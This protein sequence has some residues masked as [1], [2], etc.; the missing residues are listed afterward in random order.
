MSTGEIS[1]TSV[2]EESGWPLIH[3]ARSMS[4]MEG[5]ISSTGLMITTSQCASPSSR[6]EHDI[7][8]LWAQQQSIAPGRKSDIIQIIIRSST[9]PNRLHV[10]V[11]ITLDKDTWEQIRL[12]EWPEFQQYTYQ[13]YDESNEQLLLQQHQVFAAPPQVQFNP[14]RSN[15]LEVPGLKRTKLRR[16]QSQSAFE[17]PLHLGQK[18]VQAQLDTGIAPTAP[19][20]AHPDSAEVSNVLGG[21]GPSQERTRRSASAALSVM[22]KHAH[23]SFEPPSHHQRNRLGL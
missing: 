15:M 11:N 10:K 5:S 9:I 7:T 14:S 1:E 2:I 4:M 23:S 20:Y 22:H 8:E 3:H 17:I 6:S 12:L 16:P 21:S 13:K 19:L 18:N